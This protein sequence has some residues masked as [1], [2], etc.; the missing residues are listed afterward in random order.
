VVCGGCS[1]ARQAPSRFYIVGARPA[2]AVQALAQLPGVVVTGTVPDVRPY[3]AHARVAVAPLRI[4]RAHP[5]KVL[6]AMAMPPGGGV[7][8]GARGHR[9]DPR[10]RP[11][12]LP[13]PPPSSPPWRRC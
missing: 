2:A 3:I 10:H 13:T 8:A 12:R 5:D 1:P 7:A 11:A 9:G 6:E 4:A